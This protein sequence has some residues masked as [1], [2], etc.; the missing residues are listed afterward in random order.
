MRPN[1]VI[2]TIIVQRENDSGIL[3]VEEGRIIMFEMLDS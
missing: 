3:A 2:S 1:I